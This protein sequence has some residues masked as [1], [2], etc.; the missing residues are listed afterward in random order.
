MNKGI[1]EEEVVDAEIVEDNLPAR[2]G[3]HLPAA[4]LERDDPDAWLSEQAKQDIKSGIAE[5]TNNA[6]K[7][8]M[9]Q[10]AEWCESVGRRAMP[11]ASESVTEYISH[12]KR[13]PREATGKPYNPSTMDRIIAAIR[14]SHRAAKFQPPDTMAA[15]KVVAGYR[16][17]LSL[18]KDPAASPRKVSPADRKVLRRALAHLDRATLAGKRDAA[19]MLLGHALASRG[20]ELVPL[21][22][23][24]SFTPLPDGGFVVDV[25][26]KKRK[27]WQKVTV[28]LDPEPGLCAVRAVQELVA[29]LTE[30]GHHEGP[31]F[32]RM[33]RWGFLAPTMQRKG[34]EIGDPLGRITVEAA[35]DIV[36][37]SIERAKIPGRWRSH[38]PRMGLVKSSRAAGVDIVQIG[39]HGGWD[40]R[41]KALIGYIDEMDAEGEG[42]P[43]AQIGK[44]AVQARETK[45]EKD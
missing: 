42:N 36:Q 14:S 10:F 18:A 17:E 15:R 5:N 40:D 32:V 37:R 44:A 13:T 9:K 3:A 4:R 33:D 35:S 24:G 34:K 6:Y 16:R 41:S 8:D 12:L 45:T 28:P 11:A 25:Y 39:R 26:R 1:H 7:R 22:W 31:L 23:P 38:S 20:S 19:L 30:E 43:L 2:A 21:D 29:T 27:K